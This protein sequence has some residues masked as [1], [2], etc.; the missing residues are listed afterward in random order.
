MIQFLLPV[1]LNGIWVAFD[2]GYI[3]EVLGRKPWVPIPG[4]KS[5]VPGILGWRGR[6]VGVLDLGSLLNLGNPLQAGESRERTAVVQIGQNT[7]AIPVDLVREVQEVNEQ[8][9][10]G[11]QGRHD[12]LASSQV[13]LN[14]VPV[15]IIDLPAVLHRMGTGSEAA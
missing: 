7:L 13:Q 8:Q 9:L 11:V 2:A 1:Q 3:Q 6:A 4:A 15:P 12:G 10:Q 14:G 5:Q